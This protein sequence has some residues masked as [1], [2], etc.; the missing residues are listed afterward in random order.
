MESYVIAFYHIWPCRKIGQGQHKI[1]I[2]ILLVVCGYAMLH[3]KFQGHLSISP[4]AEDFQRFLPYMGIAAILVMC[5][6]SFVYIILLM[7]YLNQCDE[8]WHA[9]APYSGIYLF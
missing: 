6:N 2:W 9:S 8:T 4:G 1:I 7:Q 5:P 3:T